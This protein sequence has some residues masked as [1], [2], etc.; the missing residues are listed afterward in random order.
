LATEFALCTTRLT[1]LCALIIALCALACATEMAFAADV[2]A[3]FAL[4]KAAIALELAAE[5]AIVAL[6]KEAL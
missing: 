3:D 5:S 1:L 4:L 2:W 6:C